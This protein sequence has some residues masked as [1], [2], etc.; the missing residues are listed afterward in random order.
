ML[1]KVNNEIL[2]LLTKLKKPKCISCSSEIDFLKNVLKSLLHHI[3]IIFM[4]CKIKN[5]NQKQNKKLLNNNCSK[6]TKTQHNKIIEIEFLL[7]IKIF[8]T[9]P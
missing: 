1:L 4:M 2:D 8:Y 5:Q 7:C 9:R 6:L 3:W